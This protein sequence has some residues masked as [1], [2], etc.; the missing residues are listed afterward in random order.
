M[1]RFTNPL[2]EHVVTVR[3]PWLWTLLFGPLYM[4]FHEAWGQA[5]VSFVVAC[6]TVGLSWVIYPFFARRIV[7]N[8]YLRK[9]WRPVVTH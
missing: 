1:M 6:V 8:A 7:R 4:A 3:A 5:L 2:N 9:G